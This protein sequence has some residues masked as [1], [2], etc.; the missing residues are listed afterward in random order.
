MGKELYVR[1]ISDKA[2]ENDLRKLFSVAGTVASVHL[3][4]DP[5]TDQFKGCAFVKMA[6]DNEA[7]EAITTL[8][9][10][11]LI[12]RVIMVGQARP[13]KQKVGKSAGYK[14]KSGQDNRPRRGRK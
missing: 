4:T 8:D 13:Q 1:H 11:L 2:T 14:G 9:G 5:E 12:N 6:T 3:I 7:Q 10:A